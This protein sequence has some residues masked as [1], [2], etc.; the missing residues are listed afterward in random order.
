MFLISMTIKY[1]TVTFQNTTT[2]KKICTRDGFEQ[3]AK[4]GRNSIRKRGKRRKSYGKSFP[5]VQ[6]RNPSHVLEIFESGLPGL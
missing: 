6:D 4:D 2:H 5:A 1:E 3:H